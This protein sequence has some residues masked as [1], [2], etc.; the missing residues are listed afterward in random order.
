MY[1]NKGV[2]NHE[3]SGITKNNHRVYLHHKLRNDPDKHNNL[4]ILSCTNKD[5]YQRNFMYENVRYR[6]RLLASTCS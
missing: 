6:K 1:S 3:K 2:S 5:D 4:M